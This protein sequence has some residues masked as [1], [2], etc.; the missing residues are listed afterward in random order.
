[1]KISIDK[2]A[3]PPLSIQL[4]D[5]IKDLISK[6][7]FKNGDTLP[8]T[9]MLSESLGIHRN[10]VISAYKALEAEGFV[11]SHV[12]RGTFIIIPDRQPTESSIAFYNVFDWTQHLSEKLTQRI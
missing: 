11:Y 7:H 1:M 6:G 9:R 12:G 10:T 3:T 8:T 4:K 2:N 5:S